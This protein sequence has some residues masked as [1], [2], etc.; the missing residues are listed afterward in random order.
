MKHFVWI[1]FLFFS[2]V[3]SALPAS[4]TCHGRFMNPISDMCWSCTMPLRLGALG[5]LS[6]GQEDNAS[7]PGKLA[8][9]C[10]LEFG[11]PIG[12]WEPSRIIEVVREP[13]CFPSLGG[14]K[15][16]VNVNRTNGGFLNVREGYHGRS[17]AGTNQQE[18]PTSFYNVHWYFNPVWFWLGVL[19]DHPCLETGYF[20]L[21]YFTEIDPLWSDS[22]KSFLLAPDSVLFTNIIAKAACAFDCVTA[23]VGFP[24]DTLFW[25][26]GCQGGIFPLDGWVPAHVGGV[27]A[28]TLLATRMLMKMHRE[29]L[30]FSGSG[31]DS[32]CGLKWDII[33]NKSDYKLQ[34]IYPVPQTKKIA[35]KCCQPIGR[36]SVLWGVGKEFP[37]KGEDFAFQVYKKRDCCSGGFGMQDI[38]SGLPSM[39]TFRGSYTVVP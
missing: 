39:P 10:G 16:S 29:G 21:A 37:V 8:C 22:K 11:V 14:L 26:S 36:T 9:N 27:Q 17:S 1:F 12:F 34:M 13:Y 4:A 38:F 25:C 33:M 3:E 24:L 7:S 35:G 30:I 28:S 32:M 23:T 15:L 20:D 18:M 31:E 6:F 2:L 5:K 19:A